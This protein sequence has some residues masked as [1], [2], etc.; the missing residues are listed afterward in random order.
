MALPFLCTILAVM[1]KSGNSFAI[2]LVG[3]SVIF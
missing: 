2:I 1:R 3:E